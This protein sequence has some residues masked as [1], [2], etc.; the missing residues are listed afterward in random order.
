MRTVQSAVFTGDA[1]PLYLNSHATADHH[2]WRSC[3]DDMS[4][5][6]LCVGHHSRPGTEDVSG[7]SVQLS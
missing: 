3:W 2:H 1:I 7:P 6:P 5:D 4:A